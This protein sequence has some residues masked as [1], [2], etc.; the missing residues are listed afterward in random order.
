MGV[1]AELVVG[2]WVGG[3]NSWIRFLALADGSG[4]A[5]ARPFYWDF[6]KRLEN[7]NLVD[8]KKEFFQPEGELVVLDCELYDKQ[9][10]PSKVEMDKAKKNKEFNDNFD[11][12]EF[13]H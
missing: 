9:K 7:D 1:S 6:M 4:G 13:Q 5:M 3:E 2:T 8:T 11:D 10:L 12:E